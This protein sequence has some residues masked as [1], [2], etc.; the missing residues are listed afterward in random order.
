MTD[1]LT[2]TNCGNVYWTPILQSEKSGPSMK[3][4]KMMLIFISTSYKASVVNM[5]PSAA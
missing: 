4:L 2:N 5:F 1:T 3:E